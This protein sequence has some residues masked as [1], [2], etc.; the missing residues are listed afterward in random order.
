[1]QSQNLAVGNAVVY[2]GKA[3]GG[4]PKKMLTFG[5]P[6]DAK[7]I[8]RGGELLDIVLKAFAPSDDTGAPA[9]VNA[10]RVNPATQASLA[11]ND[12]ESHPVINLKSANYGRPD[13][14]IKIKVESGAT[15]GK[16][17]S[18]SQGTDFIHGANIG[19][20]ALSVKYTGAEETATLSITVDKLS[21]TAGAGQAVDIAFAEYAKVDALVDKINSLGG[22][23]AEVL[24]RSGNLNTANGLDFVAAQDVK[25]NAFTVRADLQ[26]IVDW[27]N[28]TAF[29]FVIAERAEGVGT[30]PANIPYTFMSGGSDGN[31]TVSDWSDALAELQNKNV[32]WVS[33]VTGDA[34]IHAMVDS[35]VDFCSNTLRRERRAILGTDLSTSDEEAIAAAKAINS[36]RTS[37]VHIG[38]YDYG[39]DG[40][41][42]LRPP[43]MT[44][45]LIAAAFAGSSPG[46]PMTNKSLKIR[47]LEREV[48]NPTET[49]PLLLGGVIPVENTEE[50]Y[51][52]VQSITTWLGDQKFN[53]REQ[54]CGAA[55][56]YTVQSVRKALNPL[57][58]T[59]QTPLLMSRGASITK[60]TLTELAKPEPQGP[61]VLAGD[62]NSPAF[63]NIRAI[64]EGDV[65]G[66]EFECSPV[67]PNNYIL[68]TVYA[69]PYSGSTTA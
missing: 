58:G 18:V 42:E 25:T 16:T 22:Y 52:V 35:H 54:S 61:Q 32:A 62:E 1:M 36:K 34:A 53:N 68:V 64:M 55:L 50:G 29:Q 8:L 59:K 13:N 63:R 11:L 23:V 2:A 46:T 7:R 10:V 57:R 67:V 56:D 38:H 48:L 39:L 69:K 66:V 17:I 9:S 30:L 21:L 31:T 3:N 51:K 4:I 15:S 6:E 47:G 27:F 19:R 5:N 24:D 26:A 65:L 40:K 14:Q 43:Y 37:L 45:G 33:A 60:T 12:S 41:L 20:A 44:A 49:D 28:N